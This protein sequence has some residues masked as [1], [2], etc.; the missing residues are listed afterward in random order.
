MLRARLAKLFKRALQFVVFMYTS[1]RHYYVLM[2]RGEMEFFQ[3][4]SCYR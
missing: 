3:A 1:K 4:S 2:F